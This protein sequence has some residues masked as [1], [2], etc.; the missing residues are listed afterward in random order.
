MATDGTLWLGS[1]SGTIGVYGQAQWTYAPSTSGT[2]ISLASL[3][4]TLVAATTCPTSGNRGDLVVAVVTDI[5]NSFTYRITG[6]QT[7]AAKTGNY[8]IIIEQL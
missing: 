5:T 2:A 7:G 8:S 4:T 1:T 6:Q 3:T